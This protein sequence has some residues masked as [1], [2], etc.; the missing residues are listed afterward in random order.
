MTFDHDAGAFEGG[1]VIA[2]HK[3]DEA[4]V[5]RFQERAASA[6][7]KQAGQSAVSTICHA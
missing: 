7:M 4:I 5:V 2:G 6:Q 3:M 1:Q